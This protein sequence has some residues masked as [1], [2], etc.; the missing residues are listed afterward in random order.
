M[1]T[2]LPVFA[3]QLSHGLASLN[4]ADKGQSVVLM[5][6]VAEEAAT[7]PHHRKKLIFLFSAMRHFAE[8]LKGAGWQ[9]DY[10]TLDDPDNAGDFTGEIERALTRHDI[11]Q[12]SVTEPSEYRVLKLVESWQEKTS[13]PVT[14]HDDD[15]FL[16]SH[17]EFETWAAGRKS[18]RMEYFYR[19]MRK[20]TE[21]LMTGDEP[22]GGQWNYDK[23]NR[24][25]AKADLLMPKPIRFDP[26]D[27]TN[28]VIDMI[29]QRY[30]NRY[31][32]IE[33]FAFA[34]TREDALKAL[35][36]FVTH[37]LERFGD[38][39]DAMLKGE[40]FLYHSLLSAYLNAGLLGWREIVTAVEQAYYNGN[41]PLNA[42]E[43]YIRQIIGW[44]EYVRG[45]YWLEMPDYLTVNHFAANRPLP[46]FYWTAETDMACMADALG[47]TKRE[48]YAHHIQRLMVTG[49][50]ALIA[51][52]NPHA[53][54]EWYLSV[55]IDAFEWV[56]APNT[57]GMSQFADGGLLAS[58]PYAAS[59]NYI[60]KMSDYCKGCRYSVKDRTGP[61]ACPFNALYWDFIARHQDQFRSNPR[62]A[63]M[64]R[65]WSRFDDDEQRAIRATAAH[66]LDGLS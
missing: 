27:I 7:V 57:I 54:H 47:Q 42:V 3:D 31:G 50:F 15:R 37:A 58:K 20:K 4:A 61:D 16:C 35:D 23:E 8:E 28:Q 39:Q 55:Y 6:E 25:P 24:K 65:V 29:S 17:Q 63:Q 33:G 66:Y 18:L 64:V 34:V 45:I 48:A 12:I 51:G 21:L 59:G 49:T 60:N 30:H 53:L 41:A 2:L 62:M 32:D 10:V 11:S 5:V 40:P 36:Y 19:D 9:V 44:R 52:I 22:E 46:D 38:Y 14:I 26:D 1:T 13:L 43:G 56:E